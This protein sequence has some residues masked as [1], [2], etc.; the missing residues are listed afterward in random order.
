MTPD[1]LRAIVNETYVVHFMMFGCGLTA[2][3]V[4][5]SVEPIEN[6][7]LGCPY[8]VVIAR[9]N[10]Q[11][12]VL[13]VAPLP[14]RS[15][16]RR[17]RRAWLKFARAQPTMPRSQLDLIVVCSKGYAN[18]PLVRQGLIDKGLVGPDA[19]QTLL[20]AWSEAFKPAAGS[21]LS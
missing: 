3:D 8:A 13:W 18:Y 11:Q 1:D 6:A 15:D 10:G 7:P 4:F 21:M 20:E 17:F 16:A 9:K 19:G 5:V 2:D 12:F 14:R